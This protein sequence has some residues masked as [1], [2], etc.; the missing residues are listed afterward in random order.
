MPAGGRRRNLRSRFDWTGTIVLVAVL[1]AYALATTQSRTRGFGDGA[2]LGLLIGAAIGAAIF[3]VLQARATAPLV[4]LRMFRD[5]RLASGAA[6]SLLV[7]AIMMTTLLLAP[8][9]LS[10]AVGLA[11][12]NIGLVMA[13]GPLTAALVGVPAGWLSDRV[14][15]TWTM[16]AGLVGLTAG[17]FWM[18]HVPMDVGVIGYALRVAV[19]SGSY[20]FFQTPNNAAVM[21][22]ARPDQRGVVSSLLNLS[23][24]LGF[25]T[26]ASLIGTVFAGAL[27]GPGQGTA[28]V[29]NASPEAL[30]R[31][32]H[33]AFGLATGMSLVALVLAALTIYGTIARKGQRP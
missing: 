8:F 16:A 22:A 15:A 4:D 25:I 12:E 5:V 18:S 14:G 30:T 7:A 27:Q 20:G 28:D 29:A 17:V 1:V 19:I 13:V 3:V 33:A 11:S 2:V 21:A 9:F 32:M 10:R 31:G 24:N 26:G 6:T 23:R